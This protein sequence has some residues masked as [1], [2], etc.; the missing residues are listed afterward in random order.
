[1]LPPTPPRPPGEGPSVEV[2]AAL[3]GHFD[4]G[5]V[6]VVAGTAATA[7]AAAGA[8]LGG[9]VAKMLPRPLPPVRVTVF[10]STAA[11]QMGQVSLLWYPSS[12]A[13]DDVTA[14]AA[15]VIGA[16]AAATAVAPPGFAAPERPKKTMRIKETKKKCGSREN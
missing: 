9:P 1:M 12:R 7:A 14:E 8:G 13:V 2:S 10:S 5:K 15:G 4:N 6:A 16:G 3:S 11:V